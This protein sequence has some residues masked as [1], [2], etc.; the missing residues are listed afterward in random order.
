MG[1]T[2]QTDF[3]IMIVTRLGAC[4]SLSESVVRLWKHSPSHHPP[5]TTPPPPLSLAGDVRSLI[6]VAT[7]LSQ[8]N[9]SF[10]TT[11]VCLLRQNVY[12]DKHIF[13]ATNII[14]FVATNTCLI[15]RLILPHPPTPLTRPPTV[16]KLNKNPSPLNNVLVCILHRFV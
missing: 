14:T 11:K 2:R 1:N 13:I 12:R 4:P 15:R 9:T 7:S 8:Q 10:V 5:P 6:F 16:K 3:L